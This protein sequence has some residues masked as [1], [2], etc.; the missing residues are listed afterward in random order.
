MKTLAPLSLERPS[1]LTLREVTLLMICAAD[2]CYLKVRRVQNEARK[3][4]RGLAVKD[5]DKNKKKR[6]RNGVAYVYVRGRGR[7]GIG[8]RWI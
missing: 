6:G 4:R 5:K 1:W 8:R 7:G 3:E 2:G